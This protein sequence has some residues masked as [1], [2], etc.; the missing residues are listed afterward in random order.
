[1]QFKKNYLEMTQLDYLGT[2]LTACNFYSIF[3]YSKHKIFQKINAIKGL[4]GNFDLL[5]CLL[6]LQYYEVDELYPLQLVLSKDDP[7]IKV[8]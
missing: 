8:L 1:M 3:R 6:L 4:I 7:E 5:S 2:F